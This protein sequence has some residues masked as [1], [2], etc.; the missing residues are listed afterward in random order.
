MARRGRRTGSRNKNIGEK[1]N[2]NKINKRKEN[3][4]ENT[5]DKKH[6][7]HYYYYYQQ[8]QKQQQQQQQGNTDGKGWVAGQVRR[9]QS[10]LTPPSFSGLNKHTNRQFNSRWCGW[11]GGVCD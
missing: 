11:P 6:Q 8:Q 4:K 2:N 3:K 7:H 5:K 9:C 10:L 1:K